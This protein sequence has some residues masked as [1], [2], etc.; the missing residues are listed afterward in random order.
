MGEFW[1][2][3]VEL[4]DICGRVRCEPGWELEPSW[5]KQLRDYDLWLVW[6]GRG[7]MK[8]R[9]REIELVPGTCVWM[10]PGGTYTA[11]QHP[12][13]RLGVSYCH[14]AVGGEANLPAPFEVTMVRSLDFAQ[15]MM[16]EIVRW[17]EVR[18]ELATR[19]LVSLLEVFGADHA[20]ISDKSSMRDGAGQGHQLGKVRSMAARIAEEPGLTW[21]VG[22]MAREMGWA[23]DHFSR[24]FQQVLG[25]RPQYYVLTTRINRA[26][27][28]LNETRLSVSEI[29]HAMG[30]R[31]GFY[32]SRQF[33]KRCGVAPS[34]YRKLGGGAVPAGTE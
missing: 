34:A 30:F 19:L 6:A 18:P 23:P 27:Q 33:R 28:L 29:A 32:F 12:E 31:D 21:S 25:Q 9:D 14:F 13:E 1:E 3:N 22:L 26:R 4:S 5:S 16:A 24:I 15:S 20:G 8:L 2:N 10:R 7:R 11:R 17:R